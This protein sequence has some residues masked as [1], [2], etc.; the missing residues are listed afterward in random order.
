MSDVSC[1]API[2]GLLAIY[3]LFS[4]FYRVYSALALLIPRLAV[5]LANHS[6]SYEAL[7]SLNMRTPTC[8]ELEVVTLHCLGGGGS[9][10]LIILGL[11]AWL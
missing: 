2:W 8:F 5:I 6:V 10:P 9:P 1:N 11:L 7:R 4:P 3:L